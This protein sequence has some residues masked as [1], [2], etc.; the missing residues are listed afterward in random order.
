MAPCA[1]GHPENIMNTNTNKTPIVATL[2]HN[3]LLA[4]ALNRFGTR[5]ANIQAGNDVL[6]WSP[7]M[8][9]VFPG[10][11]S[12][13]FRVFYVGQDTHGWN[14][15]KEGGFSSFLDRYRSN[16]ID[17]YLALNE[18]VLATDD[19]IGGWKGSTSSF[20]FR[21]HQL[22][23]TLRFGKTF[24][25]SELGP[26]HRTALNEI[27][28]GNRFAVELPAA[29]GKHWKKIDKP[30]YWRI[31]EAAEAELNRFDL[32]LDCFEP[33][34]AF[35]FRWTWDPDEQIYFRGLEFKEVGRTVH[36]YM[37]AVV[38]RVWNGKHTTKV[39]WTCHPSTAWLNK[40]EPKTSWQDFVSILADLARQHCPQL[41]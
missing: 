19:R 22:H 8:P 34:L 27:G 25:L 26:E 38:Y 39:V 40:V 9:L 2:N 16:R 14:T 13:P 17:E 29:L 20:W 23:L 5:V 41:R 6:P 35:I 7:M 30:L 31:R 3:P 15:G 37:N 28:Y 12:A 1:I 10:Y 32:I 18:S 4:A 36:G 21:V 11:A 24:G 33:E